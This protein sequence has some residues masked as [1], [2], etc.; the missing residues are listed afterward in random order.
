M[1]HKHAREYPIPGY[2]WSM[3]YHTGGI[4]I[5]L[6]LVLI[7]LDGY[8]SGIIFITIG[9]ILTL[10]YFL[11][12]MFLQKTSLLNRYR[13]ERIRNKA[14]QNDTKDTDLPRHKKP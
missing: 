6:G 5:M 14:L 9:A 7:V 13:A 1:S 10:D 8:I 11:I 12:R 4:L 2:K 3:G